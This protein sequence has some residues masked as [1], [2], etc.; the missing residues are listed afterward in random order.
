MNSC[1]IS[2]TYIIQSNQSKDP[3]QCHYF[4]FMV[5][6]TEAEGNEASCGAVSPASMCVDC[7]EG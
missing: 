1:G 7:V 4:D 5:E 2:S 6:E 3:V